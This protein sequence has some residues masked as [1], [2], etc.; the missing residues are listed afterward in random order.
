[1]VRR[2]ALVI[3]LAS[4]F[5]T[6]STAQ[7]PFPSGRR[8]LSPDEIARVR[9]WSASE[10]L[11]NPDFTTNALRGVGVSTRLSAE[12]LQ[13]YRSR[14]TDEAFLLAYIAEFGVTPAENEA[15]MQAG[16]DMAI[17]RSTSDMGVLHWAALAHAVLIGE[18]ADVK[19]NPAGP[20]HTFVTIR[21]IEYLKNC[22]QAR[23]ALV[24]AALLYTGPRRDRL[25][26]EHQSD[27]MDEPDLKEGEKVLFFLSRVPLSLRFMLSSWA[28]N[29]GGN[30]GETIPDFGKTSDLLSLL[31][32][33]A[34]L[35]ILRAH[36]VVGDRAVLK[37][38]SFRVARPDDIVDLQSF[39]R[40]LRAIAMAQAAFCGSR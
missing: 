6:Q 37:D 14:R 31:Q 18:V 19:G 4:L 30:L 29:G 11:P 36:K 10:G 25:G 3:A 39:R 5:W 21:P 9:Q 27:A 16:V 26:H 34:T 40:K 15:L 12:Q 35:E 32:S 28:G 33:S 38:R 17:R 7:S 23:P 2:G 1:M 20:Y 13:Y 22:L 24:T 8:P